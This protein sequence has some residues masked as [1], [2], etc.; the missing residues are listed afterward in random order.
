[1]QVKKNGDLMKELSEN[2]FQEIIKTFLFECPASTNHNKK[3]C[4]AVSKRGTSF[5]ERHITGSLLITMLA[6]IKKNFNAGCYCSIKQHED[7]EG[8]YECLNSKYSD[9]YFEFMIFKKISDMPDTEGIY[10]AIRNALAH[11]EFEILHHNN[12]KIYLLE[13]HRGNELKAKMRLCEETL[14]KLAKISRMKK[15]DILK[16]RKR[17]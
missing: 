6:H 1:M 14:L 9:E 3:G 8:K 12:R 16:L 10:Y 15:S 7:I 2:N 11:G 17:K 4:T 13:N 5:Y